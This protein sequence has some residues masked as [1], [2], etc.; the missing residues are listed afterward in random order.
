MSRNFVKITSNIA[1][2]LFL[3]A[4]KVLIKIKLKTYI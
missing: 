3:N 1:A 4:K 2:T